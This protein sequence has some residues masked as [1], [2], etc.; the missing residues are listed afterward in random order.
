MVWGNW[1]PSKTAFSPLHPRII[2]T[3][4]WQDKYHLKCFGLAL[5]KKGRG[6]GTSSGEVT[7][8]KEKEETGDGF[9]FLDKNL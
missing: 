2:L 3:V 9:I 8:T 4:A 1:R 6:K 5:V 7:E